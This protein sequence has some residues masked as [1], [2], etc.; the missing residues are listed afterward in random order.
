MDPKRL[1]TGTLVGTVVLN[2]Y[3]FLVWDM[4]LADFFAAHVG[5]ATGVEKEAP[6]WLAVVGSSLLLSVLITLVLDWSGSTSMADGFK[7][8]AILG[9]LLWGGVD[10]LFY[11]FLNLFD[12]VAVGADAAL[13]A[14]QFGLAGLA[15]AAVGGMMG[16]NAA[17]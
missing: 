17:E 1:V 2:V 13:G 7:T 6:V 3:G 8:A 5:S 11:G 14:L 9:L 16:G 10:L 12:M 4:L 15:I